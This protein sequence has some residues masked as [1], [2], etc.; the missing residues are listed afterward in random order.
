MMAAR[1]PR[2]GRNSL[3]TFG[4][5][6]RLFEF[7]MGYVSMRT[8]NAA[9]S[10]TSIHGHPV[11]SSPSHTV[12]PSTR[13]PILV[14]LHEPTYDFITSPLYSTDAITFA[15]HLLLSLGRFLH[16][17]RWLMFECPGSEF[18]NLVLSTLSQHLSFPR[19]ICCSSNDNSYACS[20]PNHQS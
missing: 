4:V 3:A 9:P 6:G 8:T 16:T 1:R 17:V 14:S 19:R 13:W 11:A 12:T 2:D 10:A 7:G 20:F 5:I 15:R 18:H